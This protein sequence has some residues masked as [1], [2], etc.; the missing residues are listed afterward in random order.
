MVAKKLQYE[1]FPGVIPLLKILLTETSSNSSRFVLPWICTDLLCY[2]VPCMTF[3]STR[4]LDHCMW[5]FTYYW[6]QEE[7][8]LL[9]ELTPP[10]DMSKI[11]SGDLSPVYFGSAMNN[12]GV[13]FSTMCQWTSVMI[14]HSKLFN[15]WGCGH[16]K[17]HTCYESTSRSKMKLELM[18]VGGIVSRELSG[19]CS[20]TR[21]SQE[22]CWRSGAWVS[23]LHWVCIQ[24][25]NHCL[26]LENSLKIKY[27]SEREFCPGGCRIPWNMIAS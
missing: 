14:L 15:C 18:F 25:K 12:F 3:Q 2:C 17:V 20:S 10:L 22:W 7:I 16:G 27:V 6:T 23:T 5:L 21:Q 24:S 19:V 9:E 4:L 8:E 1:C 13:N 11:Y 26:Q